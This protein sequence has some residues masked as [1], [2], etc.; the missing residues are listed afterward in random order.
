MKKFPNNNYSDYKNANWQKKRLE[1]LTRDEFTCQS[2]SNGGEEVYLHVHHIVYI[3]N[4]KVWDYPDDH[5]ITVCDS[6]HKEI[7]NNKDASRYIIDQFSFNVDFSNELIMI[8]TRLNTLRGKGLL[9]VISE[10]RHYVEF[11]EQKCNK[12]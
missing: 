7:H 9:F 12:L 5:L 6:C 1:I 2:C 3:E 8:L 11:M 4:K 10:I